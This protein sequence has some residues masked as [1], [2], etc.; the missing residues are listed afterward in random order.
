MMSI[1]DLVVVDLPFIAFVR[2]S[3]ANRRYSHWITVE[4]SNKGFVVWDSG[5]PPYEVSAAEFMGLWS[6]AGVIVSPRGATSPTVDIL[7]LRL[8]VIMAAACVGF[9]ICWVCAHM[10]PGP[11]LLFESTVLVV[12]T[13]ATCCGGML[14]FGDFTNA[15]LGLQVATAPYCK[16][17]AT[18]S[19]DDAV[20]RARR[21][22]ALL[23]DA[24][25]QIDFEADSIVGSIN[26]PMYASRDD[27]SRFFQ[28]VDRQ[29]HMYVYCQSRSCDF[30]DTVGRL[31]SSLG[32]SNV[33]VCIEGIAEYRKSISPQVR[34]DD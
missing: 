20:A 19:I 24:R 32:F 3:P 14:L 5:R 31:L 17:F 6:G 27:A 16:G 25:R 1:L 30:D 4:H 21:P 18:V 11:S 22:D 23:I 2:S 12:L 9:L 26:V 8:A 29:T 7:F 33:Y 34:S 28:A 15:R 10:A 13:L